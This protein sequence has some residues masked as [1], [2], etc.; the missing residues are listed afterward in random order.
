MKPLLPI[1]LWLWPCLAIAQVKEVSSFPKKDSIKANSNLSL[2]KDSFSKASVPKPE[3]FTSGFIDIINNGQVNASARFIRLFIGEP[4]KLS[5]PLSFY[6]GVSANNFQNQ[7]GANGLLRSNDHLVTQYINPLSGLI[8]ISSDGNVF[9]KKTEKAT[10]AGWLYHFG[11]RVMT[12]FKTGQANNPQT[13]KPVNFLNSFAS[14]GLYFQTG[15][16]ERTNSKNVGVCWLAMRYHICY[17]NPQQIRSFLPDISTN[18]VYM[19][20]SMAFGVEINN[21]V[22]LKVIYYKYTKEPEIDY[23][24]PIYQFSFNYSLK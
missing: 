10:K 4:G 16:W 7:T 2:P 13:G 12:G 23:S 11:E 9:F 20:Y 1:L 21:L 19:G 22:N 8:N 17:T 5:I 14:S 15:A 3:I 24:L 18:G 6:S